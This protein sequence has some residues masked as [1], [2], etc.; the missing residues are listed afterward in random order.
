MKRQ[1]V[2]TV[3]RCG[4]SCMKQQGSSLLIALVVM[5]F[6][7]T[8]GTIVLQTAHALQAMAIECLLQRPPMVLLESLNSYACQSEGAAW[9]KQGEQTAGVQPHESYTVTINGVVCTVRVGVEK[10]EVIVRSA[11]TDKRGIEYVCTTTL[12]CSSKNRSA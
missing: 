4:D 9:C 5:M 10:G 12:A 2:I 6:I 8:L 3:L 11:C 1:D 7:T